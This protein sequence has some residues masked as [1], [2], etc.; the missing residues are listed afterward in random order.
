MSRR[1]FL[2]A[3]ASTV[4]AAG[5]A[6]CDSGAGN[7]VSAAEPLRILVPEDDTTAIHAATVR[8]FNTSPADTG[9]EA[10][11]ELRA[12]PAPSY[13][14]ALETALDGERGPD[15]LFT[16]GAGA[17]RVSAEEHRLVDLYNLTQEYPEFGEKLL[18]GALNG[19]AVNNRPFGIP[20]RGTR[21]VVLFHHR[22]LFADFGLRPPTTWADLK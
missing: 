18:P 4:L 17:I 2:G 7:D 1:C 22:A 13:A 9:V 3:G 11:A 16:W 20:V 21:P 10:T 14:R 19:C 6:G 5:V 8:R 12:A 15:L